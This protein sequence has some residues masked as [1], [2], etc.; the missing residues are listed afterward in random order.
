MPKGKYL[1]PDHE[2]IGKLL[3]QF[4]GLDTQQKI[5]DVF[6][7]LCMRNFYSPQPDSVCNSIYQSIQNGLNNYIKKDV[8]KK[9]FDYLSYELKGI[10]FD[11]EYFQSL[12]YECQ[13]AIVD[14]NKAKTL[15]KKSGFEV[16]NIDIEYSTEFYS[17]EDLDI[18]ENNYDDIHIDLAPAK[19]ETATLKKPKKEKKPKIEPKNNFINSNI[20]D[21]DGVFGKHFKGKT[22]EE[23]IDKDLSRNPLARLFAWDSKQINAVF[24]AVKEINNP[25]SEFEDYEKTEKLKNALDDYLIY[26]RPQI[27][28]QLNDCDGD[29]ERKKLIDKN[30]VDFRRYEFC[31]KL[32]QQIP[33]LPYE[34]RTFSSKHLLD[35][36]QYT[37]YERQDDATLHGIERIAKAPS[38]SFK[39][40]FKEKIFT[41]ISDFFGSLFSRSSSR[42]TTTA[43]PAE[44]NASNENVNENDDLSEDT[45]FAYQNASKKPFIIISEKGSNNKSLSSNK[46]KEKP[47]KKTEIEYTKEN[48]F[49]ESDKEKIRDLFNN[50]RGGSVKDKLIEISL[51]SR[52]GLITYDD[53]SNPMEIF[54]LNSAY[55]PRMKILPTSSQTDLRDFAKAVAK[56]VGVTSGIPSKDEF[57]RAYEILCGKTINDRS[58]NKESLVDNYRSKDRIFRTSVLEVAARY[59]EELNDNFVNKENLRKS[60][61]V[62]MDDHLKGDKDIIDKKTIV[63]MEEKQL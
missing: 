57:A 34:Y 8:A 30:N 58:Q 19:E 13:A 49:T 15:F 50:S 9:I 53:A 36:T 46:T 7:A 23:I 6:C 37:A 12:Y 20:T 60:I 28:K 2:L 1:N 24:A 11:S 43:A 56:V 44:H 40:F 47:V 26:K 10:S 54:N 38:F 5:H 55:T 4:D 29:L 48:P 45:N 51:L 31:R 22:I 35:Y 59:D 27:E 63:N 33:N 18:K 42:E 25:D 41:P 39:E 14:Q 32:A 62:D 17:M 21:F 61:N 3:E 52:I 16:E